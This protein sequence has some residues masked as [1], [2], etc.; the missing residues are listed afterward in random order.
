MKLWEI[1][2]IVACAAIV[3]GVV[4]AAVVRKVKGKSGCG[5]D[6]ASCGMC[7]HCSQQDAKDNADVLEK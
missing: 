3:L 2:L 6:C 1:L 4:I 7:S 5:C